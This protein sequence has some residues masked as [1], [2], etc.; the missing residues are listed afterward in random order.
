MTVL[1]GVLGSEIGDLVLRFHKVGGDLTLLHL[2]MHKEVPQRYV[3]RAR[4]V[5]AIAGD[6]KC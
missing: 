2:F 5:C 1:V 4:A 3:L 6:V